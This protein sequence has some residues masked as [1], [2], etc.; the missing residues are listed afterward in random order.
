MIKVTIIY[1]DG[2][3]QGSHMVNLTQM[4]R[5]EASSIKAIME[6]KYR[7]SI[8]YMFEGWPLMVG[9]TIEDLNKSE[10]ITINEDSTK[11]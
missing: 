10:I 8:I 2:W 7:D 6:S 9:E 5:V 11:I 4:A 1:L 3:L